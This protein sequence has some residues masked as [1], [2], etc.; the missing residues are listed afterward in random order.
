MKKVSDTR[1]K[2]SKRKQPQGQKAATGQESDERMKPQAQHQDRGMGSSFAMA[3]ANA[4]EESKAMKG[5]QSN[6]LGVPSQTI[7]IKEHAY[8][9][10]KDK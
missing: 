8:N 5:S 2:A 1:M 4:L 10:A 6:F 3:V 7:D 9:L